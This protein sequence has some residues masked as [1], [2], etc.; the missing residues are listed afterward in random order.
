VSAPVAVARVGRAAGVATMS[1]QPYAR[2]GKLVITH[3]E[4][5]C[6]I[7]VGAPQPSSSGYITYGQI[8]PGYVTTNTNPIGTQPIDYFSFPWLGTVACNFERYKFRTLRFILETESPTSVGGTICMALDANAQNDMFPYTQ[9]PTINPANATGSAKALM[10]EL[11]G[12]CR[13]PPWQSFS[14]DCPP[15]MYNGEATYIATSPPSP[16]GSSNTDLK[17]YS[18]GRLLIGVFGATASSQAELYAEYT[19]ELWNPV[20]QL[21][22]PALGVAPRVGFHYFDNTSITLATW[23][24]WQGTMVTLL[25]PPLYPSATN[26]LTSA[27]N[28]MVVLIATLAGTTFTAFPTLTSSVNGAVTDDGGAINA[29]GNGMEVKWLVSIVRG[30][31]LTFSS[32]ATFAASVTSIRLR[33]VPY[34]TLLLNNSA[35]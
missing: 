21:V 8:N 11:R 32:A 27:V 23:L 30:E 34:S 29:A 13:S 7:S 20:N 28:G 19:V 14:I 18:Y 9:Q 24:D 6:D 25:S 26:V 33:C 1:G 5:M 22:N 3:R 17:T 10:M 31:R 16:S 12:A 2:D 35:D 4:Y 15:S